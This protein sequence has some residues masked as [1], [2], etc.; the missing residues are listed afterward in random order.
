MPRRTM[1]DSK[2]KVTTYLTRNLPVTLLNRVRAQAHAHGTTIEY[3][4]NLALEV[5]LARLE[6]S[7]E[8]QR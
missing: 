1:G 2:V 8:A 5:G 6:R 3:A 4:L 7:K